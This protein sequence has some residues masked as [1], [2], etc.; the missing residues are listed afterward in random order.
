MEVELL[1]NIIAELQ[2]LLT[3]GVIS[4]VHQPDE[5]T[6]LLKVF[7]RGGQRALLISTDAKVSRI[8]LT[9]NKYKNPERPL[10]FC[11]MLRSRITNAY[12]AAIEQEENERIVRIKLNKGRGDAELQY[13]LT[14]EL[15]G[16]SA[17]IILTDKDN[18]ILDAIKYF[19][20]ESSVR[21]VESGVKLTPLP[22][23][24]GEFKKS[25][26]VE[27]VK[28]EDESW[29]EAAERAYDN[30]MAE[31]KFSA[32]KKELTRA[33]K[34]SAKKAKRM[35]ENLNGDKLKAT[36]A[37]EAQR[38]GELLLNAMKEIKR[39]MSEIEVLDYYTSPPEKVIVPLDPKKGAKENVDFIFK[40]A[41]KAKTTLKLLEERMPRIEKEAARFESLLKKCE[42]LEDME[43]AE[44]LR[45]EF[46]QSGIIKKKLEKKE[47]AK[48]RSEPFVKVRSTEGFEMLYGK[49]GKGNDLLVKKFAKSDD[50]WFH[51]KGVAGAHVILRSKGRACVFTKKSIIEAATIA[52]ENCKASTAAKVEVI[53]AEARYVRKAKGGKAG[54]VMVDEYKSIMVKI[55]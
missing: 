26:A 46:L 41:K 21:K 30:F 19:S 43:K 8:Y 28:A 18:I 22:K 49:S 34:R 9:K 23:L 15:T 10:R 29:S 36:G 39:G 3:S 17:N 32:L 20:D 25:Q 5:R 40:K 55:G 44:A 48:Q 16:K 4:K 13:T 54:A 37:L 6:L 50:L 52:A 42:E 14:I 53:Y 24:E 11:A 7:A 35:I 27:V 2:E 38:L 1:K 51:A 47:T 33:V 45:G 31:D 12:I